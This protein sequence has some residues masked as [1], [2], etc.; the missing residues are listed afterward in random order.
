V[1]RPF[2]A[3][4]L[5][6]A[7]WT[8][9]Q[10]APWHGARVRTPDVLTARWRARRWRYSGQLATRS[11]PQARGG[12]D[13]GAGQGGGGRG[14]P[15]KAVIDEVAGGCLGSGACQWRQSSG[16]LRRAAV[17]SGWICGTGR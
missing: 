4:G 8:S 2:L 12:L 3:H 16:R 7:A 11:S 6:G 9:Q 14:S 17:T 1:H 15:E 13:G 10:T 5:A